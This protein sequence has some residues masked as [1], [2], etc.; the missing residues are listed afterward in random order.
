MIR[1]STSS[2]IGESPNDA[3]ND[4]QTD[5]RRTLIVNAD[6]PNGGERWLPTMTFAFDPTTSSSSSILHSLRGKKHRPPSK[7]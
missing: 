4:P 2:S 3:S 1:T 5:R 7:N 6:R